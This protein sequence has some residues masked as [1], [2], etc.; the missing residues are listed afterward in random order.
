MFVNE[1]FKQIHMRFADSPPYFGLSFNSLNSIF[2]K[3]FFKNF[4]KVLAVFTDIDCAFDVVSKNPSPN[5]I[6]PNFSP[7]IFSRGSFHI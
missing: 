2:R 7:M 1:D 3:Q 6:S 4:S 5:P